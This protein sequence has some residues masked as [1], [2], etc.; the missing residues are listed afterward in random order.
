MKTHLSNKDKEGKKR[1]RKRKASFVVSSALWKVLKTRRLLAGREEKQAEQVEKAR[2]QR[3]L[4]KEKRRTSRGAS[5]GS[6]ARR[7]ESKARSGVKRK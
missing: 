1:S 7:E 5:A 6:K 3:E 4:S 2:K